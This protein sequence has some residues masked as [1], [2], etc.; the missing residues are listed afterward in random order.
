MRA[1]GKGI[2]WIIAGLL[3]IV[4]AVLVFT[5]AIEPRSPGLGA[6][7]RRPCCAPPDWRRRSY[8]HAARPPSR[9]AAAARREARSLV[10][11]A[12]ER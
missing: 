12:A 2:A 7:Q 1:V 4:G 8:E 11:A 5:S 6:S 3:V 9:D 10:G